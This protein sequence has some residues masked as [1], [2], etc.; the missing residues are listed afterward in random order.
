MRRIS[1]HSAASVALAAFR[2]IRIMQLRRYIEERAKVLMLDTR[3]AIEEWELAVD[4]AIR[5]HNRMPPLSHM[6]SDGQGNRPLELMSRGKFSQ[7]KC[8]E[9]MEYAMAPGMLAYVRRSDKDMPKGSNVK[10]IGRK[11]IARAVRAEG[12]VMV[13]QPV[14]SHKLSS[15]F[16]CHRN[17]EIIKLPPGQCGLHAM[18]IQRGELPTCCLPKNGAADHSLKTAQYVVSSLVRVLSPSKKRTL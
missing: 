17:A 13:W 4:H 5:Q 3:L 11:V 9:E 10:Q 2:R 6:S 15:Q 16:R 14:D 18:G 7:Q 8:D 1:P 12:K